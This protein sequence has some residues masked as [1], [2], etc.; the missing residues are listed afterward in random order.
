M[1]GWDR[2]PRVEHPVPWE[3]FGGTM[4]PHQAWLVL[5]GVWPGSRG[6]DLAAIGGLIP[7]GVAVYAGTLWALRVE[8]REDLAAM[9]A[10]VRG[11]F[12]R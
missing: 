4:D 10:K 3:N 8:G 2:R 11:R 1:A 6:A 5:R 12:G 9:L 7:L